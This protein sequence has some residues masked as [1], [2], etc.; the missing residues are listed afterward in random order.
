MGKLG[1]KFKG[2][3]L[4]SASGKLTCSFFFDQFLRMS[5]PDFYV[6]LAP[7]HGWFNQPLSMTW[8]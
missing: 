2:Y 8:G 1:C 4:E 5:Y 3:R 7:C 6:S